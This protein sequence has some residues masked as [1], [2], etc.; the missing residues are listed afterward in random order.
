MVAHGAVEFIRKV[1]GVPFVPVP[2]R[3]HDGHFYSFLEFHGQVV[4]YDA[5]ISPKMLSENCQSMKNDETEWCDLC[6]KYVFLSKADK[7]RHM[8]FVHGN[9]GNIEKLL[10][11]KC[12]VCGMAFPTQYQCSKH[13]TEV[14]HLST[15]GRK[16]KK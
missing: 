9:R 14:G 16:A 10:V 5:N 12:K 1:G 7:L 2:S 6:N 11:H 13:K 4:L 8:K 3:T 15:K